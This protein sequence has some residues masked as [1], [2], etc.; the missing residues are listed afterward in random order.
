MATMTLD[1]LVRQLEAAFGAE[2]VS[3]ILYGSAAAGEHIAKRSDYNVL[4]LVRSLDLAALQREAPI[5]RAWGEAGNPPPKTMTVDEWRASSDIFAM[6]YAD[7]LARHRVLQGTPP[8]D[9]ITIRPGDLRL[10]L[11]HEAMGLLLQLRQRILA[12]GNEPKRVLD[13]LAGMLSAFM[14]LFRATL[15]LHGEEPSR[16]YEVLARQLATRGGIDAAPFVQVIHHLRGGAKIGDQD[17]T[18]V[19]AGY[20]SGAQQL[21]AHIDQVQPS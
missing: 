21:V 6:E 18:A 8:F 16:D 12:A 7:I 14:V 20:L 1:E 19:L 2:L 10:Q 11:E 4:V 15:R 13:V 9:G 5:A 3:V 17:A